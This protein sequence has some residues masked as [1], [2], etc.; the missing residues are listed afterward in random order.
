Q[1]AV[2]NA[3]PIEE[4]DPEQSFH[5]LD[6]LAPKAVE[7]EPEK[8][9]ALIQVVGGLPLALTL[10]GKYLCQHSYNVQP[11]RTVLALETLNNLQTRFQIDEPHVQAE[12]HPS[13]DSS[14]PISLQSI[15]AVSDRFLTPLVRKTLYALSIFSPKPQSFSED[16]AL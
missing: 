10:L 6:K 8:V 9:K 3:L 11:R 1:M 2:K 13:I 5:L 14:Q 16:A 7:Y 15:I 4:L 12:A